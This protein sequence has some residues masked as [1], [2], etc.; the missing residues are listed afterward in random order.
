MSPLMPAL[1]V[2]VL[3]ATLLVCTL[4][5]P[6]SA[7]LVLTTLEGWALLSGLRHGSAQT[8]GVACLF[9]RHL[10][11]ILLKTSLVTLPYLSPP[12]KNSPLPSVISGSSASFPQDPAWSPHGGGGLGGVTF[13]FVHR[14][15]SHTSRPGGAVCSSPPS[16]AASFRPGLLAGHCLLWCTD[17]AAADLVLQIG[18]LTAHPCLK[19]FGE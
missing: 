3:R 17:S 7:V 13:P 10:P 16:P 5:V 14:L 11:L 19:S 18:L 15:L 2:S 12:A 4:W 9:C 8:T 6:I 1:P